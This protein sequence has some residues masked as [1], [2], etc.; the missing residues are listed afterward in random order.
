MA[1]THPHAGAEARAIADS[2][3]ALLTQVGSGVHGTSISGQDDRDEMGFCFEPA[4]FVTGNAR[5]RTEDGLLI[6]FEQYE[7]HTAWSRSGG[8]AERSGPDDLDIIVY[9]ARK[10]AGLAAQGNPTVLLPLFVP[11]SEVVTITDAGQEVRANADR[12]ISRQAAERFLGYLNSQRSAI[13]SDTHDSGYNAKTAMHAMRL[14]IQGIELLNTGRISLPIPEP[15]LSELRSVRRGETPVAEVMQRL[16]DVEADLVAAAAA[17]ALPEF[18]D[19]ARVD[20]WLHRSYQQQWELDAA[21][22]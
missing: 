16:D 8:L 20:A 5:V 13:H 22:L 11:D 18:A 6:R 14:G 12:F 2:S 15:F 3:T 10:W 17:S 1:A 4:R 21:A 9:S 19:L 7:M